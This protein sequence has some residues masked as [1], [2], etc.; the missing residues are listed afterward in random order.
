VPRRKPEQQKT[1]QKK[2][3]TEFKFKKNFEHCCSVPCFKCSGFMFLVT[4]KYSPDGPLVDELECFQC[5]KIRRIGPHDPTRTD[6]K[7]PKRPKFNK[8]RQ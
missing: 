6:V 3:R 7:L 5:K 8:F 2:G 1:F 4:C